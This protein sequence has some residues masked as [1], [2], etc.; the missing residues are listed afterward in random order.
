LGVIKNQISR[1]LA[2]I[3]INSSLAIGKDLIAVTQ[4]LNSQ[5]QSVE[6]PFELFLQLPSP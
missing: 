4:S 3:A 6:L 5:S 2:S 1:T